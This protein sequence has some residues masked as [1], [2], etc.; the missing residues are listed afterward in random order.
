MRYQANVG[1]GCKDSTGKPVFI[2]NWDNITTPDA[3]SCVNVTTD[4]PYGF[5]SGKCTYTDANIDDDTTTAGVTITCGWIDGVFEDDA[6]TVKES[7]N[8]PF[9][10]TSQGTALITLNTSCNVNDAFNV[11][12]T[13]TNAEKMA[14]LQCYADYYYQNGPENDP[15]KCVRNIRT[16][17]E[18]SEPSKFIIKNNGPEK[19]AS[20]F[21][22]SGL[23]YI[24]ANTAVFED[25]EVY[26]EGINTGNSWTSCKISDHF[27]MTITK[28]TATVLEAE[29]VSTTRL[30]DLDKEAC[31]AEA[32]KADSNMTGT[33][34]SMMLLKQ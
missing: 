26:S 2:K 31:V 34:K 20:L 23:K 24:D 18:T 4:L 11:N 13:T 9:D 29:F 7:T 32:N 25:R 17:W 14:E 19:A 15:T 10:W 8:S 3:S 6:L 27:R 22:M 28:R 12:N 30:I 16:N 33:S 5:K 21:V 1:G